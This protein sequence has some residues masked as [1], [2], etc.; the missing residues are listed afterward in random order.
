M[1]VRHVL[2]T[3]DQTRAQFLAKDRAG[4]MVGAVCGGVYGRPRNSK[5]KIAG[6]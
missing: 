6:R 5:K 2:Q 1:D 3:A 4:A